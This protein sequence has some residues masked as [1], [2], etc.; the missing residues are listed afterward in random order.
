MDC[1]APS[2]IHIKSRKLLLTLVSA[3]MLSHTMTHYIAQGNQ[4]HPKTK[5]VSKFLICCIGY[6]GEFILDF[7]YKLTFSK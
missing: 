7:K 2:L 1:A 4:G 3:G 5:T 6:H